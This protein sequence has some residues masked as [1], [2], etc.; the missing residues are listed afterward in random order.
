MTINDACDN[1]TPST[2]NVAYA[3]ESEKQNE[4]IEVMSNAQN[5][6]C[7]V[8]IEII[9]LPHSTSFRKLSETCCAV[10]AIS[11]AK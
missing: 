3:V 5:K 10:W 9:K 6:D 11:K 8:N 4:D 7:Q 2:V 1:N